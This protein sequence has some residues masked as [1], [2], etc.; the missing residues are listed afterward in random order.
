MSEPSLVMTTTATAKEADAIAA[1]LV[2]RQLAACVQI[3]GP[4]TSVYR[5][6][7]AVERSEERLLLV[8]TTAHAFPRVEAAIQELHSYDCPE[9]VALPI[10]A[11]SADYLAWLREQVGGA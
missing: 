1:A 4:V 9:I 6:Q 7:G 8:K 5:W 10:D 3:V 11:G 2:E